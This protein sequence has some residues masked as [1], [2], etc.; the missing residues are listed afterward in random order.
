MGKASLSRIRFSHQTPAQGKTTIASRMQSSPAAGAWRLEAFY[1][2]LAELSGSATTAAL[3]LTFRLVLEAQRHGEPAAWITE[4]TSSFF[5]PDAARSGIDLGALVVIRMAQIQL[6]PRAA[7]HLV[8]SGGFALVVLDLGRCLHLPLAVQTRL[9][10]LA[11]KHHTA[12]LC[13]T[14]KTSDAPSLG[15]LVSLRAEATHFKKAQ[16]QFGCR[17]RVL[18]D[19]RCGLGWSHQEVFHA[20]D[21]L[22]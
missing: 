2:R 19:K 7:D 14:D 21:G 16:G 3:S 5:P 20:P 12:L 1:G 13:L 22:R 15:S 8:R 11:R 4:R 17:I 9:A 10:G 6:A 18:K